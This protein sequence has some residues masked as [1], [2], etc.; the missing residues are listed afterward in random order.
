MPL[1][2]IP[3][4]PLH[5]RVI[6]DILETDYLAQVTKHNIIFT[7]NNI[8]ENIETQFNLILMIFASEAKIPRRSRGK[9][10][11]SRENKTQ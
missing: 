2:K 9:R 6:R 7:S 4:V 10:Q 1:V 3:W 11:D 8:D 5:V